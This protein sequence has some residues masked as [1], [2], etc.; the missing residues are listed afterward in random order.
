MEHVRS[1]K[2][3]LMVCMMHVATNQMVVVAS[4]KRVKLAV[5]IYII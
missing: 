4:I 3:F 1:N 2:H 5:V